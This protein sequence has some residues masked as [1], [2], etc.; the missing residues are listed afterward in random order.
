VREVSD[1]L[2]GR[3]AEQAAVGGPYRGMEDLY[4]RT[5]T[6]LQ[7]LEALATAGAFDCFGLSRREALWAAG[8]VHQGGSDRLSGVVTGAEPPLLRDMSATE[9]AAADLWASGVAPLG[10]PTKFLRT[11]LAAAGVRTAAELLTC[12]V[13][14]V[15]V[16]GLVTHRQRPMTAGGTTFLN[17][18][19]ET[20][21]VNVVVSRGCWQRY[22][23]VARDMPVLMVSGRLE[24]SE[25]V[26][27]VIA[28]RIEALDV[29]ASVTSRDFR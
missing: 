15:R 7:A 21:L 10:H 6:G 18:E 17:L 1:D 20:G 24:R 22:R 28:E 19:D 2:A 3:I 4:C 11:E 26:A 29:P 25:N 5:G 23:S 16:A 12:S 14:K 8:A 13:G 9:T 27:N